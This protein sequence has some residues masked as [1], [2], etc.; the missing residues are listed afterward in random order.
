[1]CQTLRDPA[2]VGYAD[3]MTAIGW[4]KRDP[5]LRRGFAASI[6]LHILGALAIPLAV[7]QVANQGADASL[8]SIVRITRVVMVAPQQAVVAKPQP[9]RAPQ[10]HRLA[11]PTMTGKQDERAK[12]PP[13]ADA[14]RS[15]AK[16]ATLVAVD[17]P[18]AAPQSAPTTAP[19]DTTTPAPAATTVAANVGMRRRDIGGT[20]PF[21]AQEHDAVLDPAV[22]KQLAALGVHVTLTVTIG[23]DGVTKDVVFQ[24][25][26]DPAIESQIRQ[27]LA[28]ANWDP[29]VCGGGIPCAGTAI[30]RL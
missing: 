22:Q 11:Q 21:G 5:N 14:S 7:V 16:P 27:L 15:R 23:D 20:L 3:V 17:A 18:T 1:M 9:K 19:V 30:I 24:P 13:S 29:A 12:I 28:D 4:W 6:A 25:D 26:V 2:V 10:P 8:V